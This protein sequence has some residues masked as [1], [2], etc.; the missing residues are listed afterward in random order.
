HHVPD[1]PWPIA[2]PHQDGDGRP[3]K[4]R[5]KQTDPGSGGGKAAGQVN[6]D[7]GLPDASLAACD[8]YDV[9]HTLQDLRLVGKPGRWYVRADLHFHLPYPGDG[10]ESRVYV[11]LQLS[12][13]RTG[14]G[15]E[16][17]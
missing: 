12:A 9:L 11:R 14:R 7:G 2:D 10:L 15:R 1:C 16:I 8:R 5:V 17:E 4:V 6:R 13:E 3:V